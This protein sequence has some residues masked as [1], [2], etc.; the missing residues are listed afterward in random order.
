MGL[1]GPICLRSA[2]PQTVTAFKRLCRGRGKRAQLERPRHIGPISPQVPSVNTA[3]PFQILSA[4]RQQLAVIRLPLTA[5]HSSSTLGKFDK[6]L[7][8]VSVTIPSSSCLA[9]PIPG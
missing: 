9:P 8:P 5:T 2:E 1:I 6:T 4:T 3:T 7:K